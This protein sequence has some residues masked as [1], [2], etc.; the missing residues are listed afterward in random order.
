MIRTA[1]ALSVLLSLWL[2]QPAAAA[3]SLVPAGRDSRVAVAA[4]DQGEQAARSA[5]GLEI[6]RQVAGRAAGPGSTTPSSGRAAARRAELVLPPAGA[7]PGS[8]EDPTDR[9][10]SLGDHPPYLPTGPPSVS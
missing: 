9:R 6:L 7:A 4:A 2:P 10:P 5:S 1:L 8:R 3:S